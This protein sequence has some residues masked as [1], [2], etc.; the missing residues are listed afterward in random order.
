M[1]HPLEQGAVPD[2]PRGT[3]LSRLKELG[4]MG[5]SMGTTKRVEGG[6]RH[7]QGQRRCLGREKRS[8]EL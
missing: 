5:K 4:L 2:A 3:K 8:L 6:A 1:A 7:N